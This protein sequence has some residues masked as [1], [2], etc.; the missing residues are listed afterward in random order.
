[1]IVAGEAAG[2][3]LKATEWVLVDEPPYVEG[4]LYGVKVLLH[5]VIEIYH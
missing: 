3:Y 1:M 5:S 2:T 4:F